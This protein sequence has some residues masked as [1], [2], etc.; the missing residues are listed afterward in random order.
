MRSASTGVAIWPI[1]WWKRGDSTRPVDVESQQSLPEGLGGQRLAGRAAGKQPVV[2]IRTSAGEFVEEVVEWRDG[3]DRAGSEREVEPSVGSG[4][5]VAAEP[6]DATRWLRVEHDEQASDSVLEPQ[7]GVI[8]EVR[9][10]AASLSGRHCGG[11]GGANLWESE[12]TVDESLALGP[13]DEVSAVLAGAGPASEPGVEQRLIQAA[14][15][16]A[17]GAEPVQ[18]RD[19][20]GA[21]LAGAERGPCGERPERCG[22]GEAAVLA[23]SQVGGDLVAPLGFETVEQLGGPRVEQIEQMTICWI[24]GRRPPGIVLGVWDGGD[25]HVSVIRAR[26]GRVPA[27][28]AVTSPTVSVP[29]ERRLTSI[30]WTWIRSFGVQPKTSQSAARTGSESRSGVWVTSR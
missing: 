1:R 20:L 12:V 25:F 29:V 28:M 15:V 10:H 14:E 30:S 19:G 16:A 9:D 21:L 27:R 7:I 5:V 17:V 26:R 24:D 8:R 23:P 11:D 2:G 6:D 13:H 3:F 18:E 4:D 22:P